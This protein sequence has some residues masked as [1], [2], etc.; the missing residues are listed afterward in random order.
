[1][2]EWLEQVDALLKSSK[3]LRKE[4]HLYILKK[5]HRNLEVYQELLVELLTTVR[6]MKVAMAERVQRLEH[7]GY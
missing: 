3:P 2:P 5:L 1:M 7:H 4:T 6:T